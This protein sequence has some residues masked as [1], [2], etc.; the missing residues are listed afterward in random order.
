MLNLAI[1][2]KPP[3]PPCTAACPQPPDPSLHSLLSSLPHRRSGGAPNPSRHNT[4]PKLPSAS[5]C[6][7]TGVLGGTQNPTRRRCR[8]RRLFPPLLST[9]PCWWSASGL[10]RWQH[11]AAYQRGK[12]PYL[13]PSP[14]SMKEGSIPL[15]PA[16]TMPYRL[17]S[18]PFTFSESMVNFWP[19]ATLITP[20]PNPLVAWLDPSPRWPDP[21]PDLS[22]CLGH[23]VVSRL[24]ALEM[25]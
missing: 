6:S 16:T 19:V 17:S 21:S 14:Q 11:A 4:F 13:R 22:L 25:Q 3:L 24:S 2:Q 8:R 23:G 9:L 20:Q 7:R 1:L 5:P 10:W 15:A 12:Q 18:A